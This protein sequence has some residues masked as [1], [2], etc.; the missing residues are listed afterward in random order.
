MKD[1][2]I[3]NQILLFLLMLMG[4]H[5]LNENLL[6]SQTGWYSVS[7]GYEYG[8]HAVYFINADTGW[9]AVESGYVSKTTT[10]GESWETQYT[11]S[12]Y[13]PTD[14][15][16]IN[17]STGWMTTDGLQVLKTENG[18]TSWQLV[19]GPGY[20]FERLMSV[21]FFNDQIGWAVGKKYNMSGID[22]TVIIKTTDGGS[23]WNNQTAGIRDF[24]LNSVFFIN[25]NVGWIAGDMGKIFTT[26]N[27]GENWIEQNSTTTESLW[28]VNFVNADT[29]CAVGVN[30]TILK[31]E[32]G[33]ADW[34]QQ[35][36]P[37]SS[38][39]VSMDFC[40]DSI[41]YACGMNGTILKTT[42]GGSDWFQQVSGTT[43]GLI[44]LD[45]VS[46][47]TGYV[48]GWYG[49]ILKTVN[50]GEGINSIE[51]RE[52]TIPQILE[53]NQNYPNPFNPETTIEFRLPRRSAVKL[54]VVNT[55]GQIVQ[56]LLND[57]LSAGIYQIN[58]NA[59]NQ[60]AGVYYAVLLDGNDRKAIKMISIK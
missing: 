26:T 36:S 20:V 16:F 15:F 40:N 34:I 50:G 22:S 17:R 27:G 46:S 8:H 32:N 1:S 5:L 47:D 45:F 39:L 18:G 35:N 57:V 30:G 56:E 21:H 59:Q 9:V 6:F 4:F 53:L 24:Q 38:F 55:V 2:S 7:W 52:N 14:L 19:Y 58:W 12:N 37:V 31:T 13:H 41:G 10:G 23:T 43:Q 51:K 28:S 11:S 48:V 25:E 44:D 29:G 60:P 42:N 33:G 49:T 54:V 3:L